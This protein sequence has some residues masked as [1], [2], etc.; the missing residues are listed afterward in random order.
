MDGAL[1]ARYDLA[2]ISNLANIDALQKEMIHKAKTL[3]TQLATNPGLKPVFKQYLKHVRDRRANVNDIIQYMSSLL[4]SLNS[5][6][7]PENADEE[8]MHSDQN[9]IVY[10]IN[11]L[12]EILAELNTVKDASDDD[13]ASDDNNN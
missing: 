10:E 11:R 3:K 2:Q 5:I 6:P 7:L 12:K 1:I 8:K 9:V 13:D 4:I